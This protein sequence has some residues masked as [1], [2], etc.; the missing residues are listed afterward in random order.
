MI[1]GEGSERRERRL[2]EEVGGGCSL[3]PLLVATVVIFGC[4]GLSSCLL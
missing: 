1:W 4:V 2:E 3:A